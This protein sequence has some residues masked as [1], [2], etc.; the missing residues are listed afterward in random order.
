[1]DDALSLKDHNEWLHIFN[2]A[3]GISKIVFS[4]EDLGK[5]VRHVENAALKTVDGLEHMDRHVDDRKC[6]KSTLYYIYNAWR[7]NPTSFVWHIHPW[8]WRQLLARA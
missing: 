2:L 5:L 8:L 4:S 3:G 7:T 6:M 1:M